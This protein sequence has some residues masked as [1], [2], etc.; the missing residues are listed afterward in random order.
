MVNSQI[1]DLIGIRYQNADQSSKFTDENA[2]DW[3]QEH[4][5][6]LALLRFPRRVIG[7]CQAIFPGAT[8][9][10]MAQQTSTTEA[11]PSNGPTPETSELP[12]NA[13]LFNSA[14]EEFDK[15]LDA[16]LPQ[17]PENEA[18]EVSGNSPEQVRDDGD[19]NEDKNDDPVIPPEPARVL[20]QMIDSLTEVE[21]PKISS[22]Q[23]ERQLDIWISELRALACKMDGHLN[24]L[25]IYKT[26]QFLG[27]KPMDRFLSI[28][29]IRE[30]DK[31]ISYE[32]EYLKIF[33]A[34]SHLKE[35]IE[36]PKEIAG[37]YQEFTPDFQDTTRQM[38]QDLFFE[39]PPFPETVQQP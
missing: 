34:L 8:G 18:E 25:S 14:P 22:I 2:W 11:E 33:L 21:A 36:D 26:R 24:K 31:K 37:L 30:K 27:E 23:G 17:E 9:E 29:L 39:P 15:N 1:R 6:L 5:D 28:G 19:N 3:L 13:I 35:D 38:W 7:A 12:K 32:N 10:V 16:V 4:P 20:K